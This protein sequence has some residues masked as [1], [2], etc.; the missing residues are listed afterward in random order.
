MKLELGKL[1][2]AKVELNLGLSKVSVGDILMCVQESTPRGHFDGKL[3]HKEEVSLYHH[4]SA[5]G[6]RPERLLKRVL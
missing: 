4:N 3:L 2:Q 1:Y 5:L 6:A